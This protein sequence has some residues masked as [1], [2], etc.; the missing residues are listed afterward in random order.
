MGRYFV[1]A[2][3]QK[4]NGEK[5]ITSLSTSDAHISQLCLNGADHDTFSWL[6]SLPVW[7]RV[8]SSLESPVCE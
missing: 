3:S 6:A 5:E 8:Y 1:L 2:L 4:H 7:K